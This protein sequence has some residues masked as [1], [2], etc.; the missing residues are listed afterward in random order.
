MLGMLLTEI[1]HIIIMLIFDFYCVNN[2]ID[3]LVIY[4]SYIHQVYIY[5]NMNIF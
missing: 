4:R 1:Q 3:P 2:T 5:L